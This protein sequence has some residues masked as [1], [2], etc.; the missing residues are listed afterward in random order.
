MTNTFGKGKELYK[1]KGF[2]KA[3]KAYAKKKEL[4][5][6]IKFDKASDFKFGGD[7]THERDHS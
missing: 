4:A 5:K 3:E 7:R 2:D 1:S 6:K